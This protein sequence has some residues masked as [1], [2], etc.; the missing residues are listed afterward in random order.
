MRGNVRELETEI[1]TIA[2]VQLLPD[3]V[4]DVAEPHATA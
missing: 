1:R 2:G 3:S 4:D